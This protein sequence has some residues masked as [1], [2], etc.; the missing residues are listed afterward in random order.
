MNVN[1]ARSASTSKDDEE[2]EKT[3]F[4][5]YWWLVLLGVVIVG[6]AGAATFVVIRK[7][8]KKAISQPTDLLPQSELPVPI[9]DSNLSIFKL[10]EYSR[11]TNIN[12]RKVGSA[13]AQGSGVAPQAYTTTTQP[14]GAT[15]AYA[16]TQPYGATQALGTSYMS[17]AT[18]GVPQQP[19][20]TTSVA[21]AQVIQQQQP[22]QTYAPQM[23]QRPSTFTVAS[24]A[25]PAAAAAAATTY[26]PPFNITQPQ[27]STGMRGQLSLVNTDKYFSNFADD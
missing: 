7:A 25:A 13:P 12:P 10:P 27:R 21:P 4:E 5:K 9:P 18:A 22:L 17:A 19:T 3:W 26:K 6:I 24:T 20:M 2:P 15:Q 8:Y 14:Y 11:I 16:R 1:P 23:T